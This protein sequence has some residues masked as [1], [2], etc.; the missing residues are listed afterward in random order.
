MWLMRDFL[1]FLKFVAKPTTGKNR[2]GEGS[3]V[4]KRALKCSYLAMEEEGEDEVQ[5]KSD[6]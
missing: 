4:V 3:L 2:V 1:I 5:S 6:E